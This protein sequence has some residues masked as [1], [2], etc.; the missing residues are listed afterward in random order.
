MSSGCVA[1]EPR[2]LR[3]QTGV[4]MRIAMVMAAVV[5]AGC[6]SDKLALAPPPGVDLSAHWKL[7]EAD[8]DD[9]QRLLQSQLANATA[10]AGPG[11]STG[12]GGRGGGQ[13]SRGGGGYP[14]G[15]VGPAMPSVIALD[16]ALRWPGKDLVIKQSGGTV[17][18]SSGAGKRV[19][20]P[21]VDRHHH[22]PSGNDDASHGR[23]DVPPPVCGWDAGTLVVQ[24]GEPDD[25][26]PPFELRFSV[27]DDG[28][29]LLEVASF[30]GGRSNGFTAS[31]VWDR[32]PAHAAGA[33][34]PG[35]PAPA[36]TTN[37]PQ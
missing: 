11:G 5:M 9:P 8:S 22:R 2:A 10:A 14:G 18:F 33:A 13:R 25:E 12:P 34:A 28:Q 19:C 21:D 4:A 27:S 31:R 20:R 24:S 32:V 3:F 7:N 1:L 35:A 37:V 17:T 30:K 29:R 36:S 26:R 6:A 15:P 16:E 23:G